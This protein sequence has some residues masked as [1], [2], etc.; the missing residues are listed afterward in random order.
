VIMR[1]CIAI[2]AVVLAGCAT[3]SPPRVSDFN[4]DSVKVSVY[5]GIAME[6]AKPRAEDLA[7]AN[8]TCGTRGRNAQFASTN[9]RTETSVNYSTQVAD[10]LY[11]CV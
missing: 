5:C 2:A 11:L 1:K 7:Q 4:G 10:H 6:C 9:F 3:S 8:A